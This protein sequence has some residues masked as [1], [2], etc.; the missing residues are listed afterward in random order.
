[1]D[2][3]QFVKVVLKDTGFTV[4]KSRCPKETQPQQCYLDNQQNVIIASAFKF[5]F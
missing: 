3:N 5:H 1:M 2:N 4:P